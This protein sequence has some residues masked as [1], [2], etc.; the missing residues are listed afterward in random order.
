VK[1]AA[2]RDEYVEQTN[3]RT[4]P[5]AER[6]PYHLP[7]KGHSDLEF[8]ILGP[9]EVARGQQ[10]LPLGSPRQRA[11]LGLLLVHANEPIARER[12]I[13]EL[14]GD[15]APKTV[16][17]VLSVYLS[18][19][20]RLLADGTGD[21]LLLTQAAGY[22]LRVPPDKLD[23][24]RFQTLLERGRRE[25]ASGEAERASLTLRDALALWR[26]PALADLAFESF[27]QTEIARLE[28][29]RLT[30]LEARIEAEL[31]LG[32]EDTLIAEL[33]T[34]VAAHPFRDGV[35]AQLML[36]LYR[37]GRQ[38]EAL[39]TYRR[40]RRMFSEELGI[41]PGP[42]LRALEGAI[43]RHDSSLEAP[44]PE[45]PRAREEERIETARQ[46]PRFVSRRTV[47]LAAALILAI[48]AALVAA[49]R[50]PSGGSLEPF[51]LAGDSVA[52]IDPQ[53]DTIVGEIPVA[54]RPAG[55]AVGEGSVWVGNRDDNTL[56]RI[57]PR[58]LDVVRTIGL[59]VAPA[60]V[61][62]G[63]GSV[64]VLS[65]EAL[66][67]VDPAINDVVDTIPLP[68]A[69]G[70]GRWNR[71]E[72]GANAV[73]VCSCA[74]PG[75]IVR[76]DAVTRS[77]VTVR[78]T[79]VWAFTYG[80]GMLWAITGWEQNTIERI[81][82][83]TNAVESIPLGRLGETSGWRYRMAVAERAVWV[84]A[85]ASL[86]RVDSTT[87]RFLGSVPLPHSEGATI[88][89]GDGAVWIANSEGVVLRI[90]PDSQTVATTIPLGTLL[91]PAEN[92]DPV[93]VGEGSVWVAVTSFA[94]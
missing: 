66:L 31:A 28:E 7:T 54:D 73:F 70:A 37:S 12:L 53:T 75:G 45:P 84:L 69:I 6:R 91:Y 74:A 67:R 79:P 27:A 33:E 59:G 48:V 39:E 44:S 83:K 47:A 30:A 19:L 61:E 77:V 90:D 11:L 80:Q 5:F 93:A 42:R 17:S 16:N 24:Y 89:T 71:L 25:L 92:G 50:Y 55:P 86:W 82:P 64:W 10:A 85:P 32:R 62:V 51:V 14:W 88:A 65:D 18:R 38:A 9:L 1:T 40:A 29:L 15:A 57:D 4:L 52:V 49:A 78:R 34:L 13:E 81:D 22:V 8:R 20:R 60:D 46:R 68:P 72:A 2:K 43:L 94:S 21:Q 63:A 56:L 3:P 36:A 76:I 35:R 26:G 41:E 23:A 58:S 87:K